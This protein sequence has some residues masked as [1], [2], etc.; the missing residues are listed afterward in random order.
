MSHIHLKG[1]N[2]MSR[3][4]FAACLVCAVA[5]ALPLAQNYPDTLWIPV[6]F[7]DFHSDRSCPEFE[8]NS[9]GNIVTDMVDSLLDSER[10]PVLSTRPIASTAQHPRPYYNAYVKYWFRPWNST[11]VKASPAMY[12]QGDSTAPRWTTTG[13]LNAGAPRTYEAYGQYN[14]T[15][16]VG[17]DTTFINK[18]IED[19]LPFRHIG[20]GVYEFDVSSFYPLDNRG[21]GNEVVDGNIPGIG[22]EAVDNAHSHNYSFSMELHTTFTFK[23]GITFNFRGDDDVWAFVNDKL[24]MDLGG[25]HDAQGGSFDIDAIAPRFGLV[26]GR[27]YNFDF[28]YAERHSAASSIRITTNIISTK[29]IDSVSI[30]AVPPDGIIQAGDTID[31]TGTVWYDSIGSDG[32]PHTRADTLRSGQI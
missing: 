13:Y 18:V 16:P 2:P 28:F 26:E 30:D 27:D 7:Y 24:A 29:Y 32:V 11:H 25:R 21:F 12:A 20:G 1:T 3:H 8:M 14:G 6:T 10:K 22:N 31:F 5:Y 15:S 19:S 23:P 17:H 4:I 9:W